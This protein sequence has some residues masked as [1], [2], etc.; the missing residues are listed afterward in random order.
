[1]CTRTELRQVLAATA[2]AQ[3]RLPDSFRTACVCECLSRLSE[4]AGSFA[5]V[6]CLL[7][8]ELLR[9][10]YV[11]A[12]AVSRA[13]RPVDAQGLLECPT[14]F[15]ECAALRARV[16]EQAARLADWHRAKEALAQDADGRNELL[17][18]A[19]TRW[20]AALSSLKTEMRGQA[21]VQETARKL[22]GLLDS[23]LQHSKA[24][25]ELQRLSLLDP[26]PRLHAQ[27]GGLGHAVRRRLLASLL[28]SYGGPALSSQTHA[29]RLELLQT[30]LLSLDLATRQETV[31]ELASHAGLVGSV[32]DF[33]EGLMVSL[34]DIDAETLLQ[35]YVAR[36]AGALA[37][38]GERR[39]FS[40]RLLQAVSQGSTECTV[41]TQATSRSADVATQEGNGLR[42]RTERSI[43]TTSIGRETQASFLATTAADVGPHAT[44]ALP[45]ALLS[46]DEGWRAFHPGATA[47]WSFLLPLV[48][49][50]EQRCAQHAETEARLHAELDALRAQRGA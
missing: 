45:N 50:L 46:I 9:A 1:M 11:D 37:T 33:V 41:A 7:R 16:S 28:E 27:V 8:S 25:D 14:Y 13:G 10:I 49:S 36:H 32:T 31:H 47:E 39:S 48:K 26:L 3:Q 43:Q 40:E 17:R 42:A 2:A 5:G 22:S 34:P 15:S 24:I 6:L 18:M 35:S 4:A 30:L 44:L 38:E 23:M 19:V 29:E 21:E 12:G 20:N